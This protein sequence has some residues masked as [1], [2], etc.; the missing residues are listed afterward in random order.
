MVGFQFALINF[1]KFRISGKRNKFKEAEALCKR[2]LDIREKCLG[3]SHPDV[4]KQLN[5]LALLCQNQGKYD[6]VESYYRRAIEIYIKTLGI[7]DPNV[8]KTKNNLASA[9]LKQQKYKE[10][11]Q[12]YKDVLTRAQEKECLNKPPLISQQQQET[13]KCQQSKNGTTA[14]GNYDA[15]GGWYKTILTDQPTVTTTLKN[16]SLLY[17]R[18]GKYEAAETLENCAAKARKDPQAI[19]QALNFVKQTNLA[20]HQ[21]QPPAPSW[22]FFGFFSLYHSE[23]WN[24]SI[25]HSKFAFF[26]KNLVFIFNSLESL[27]LILISFFSA[28]LLISF[29]MYMFTVSKAISSPNKQ[30]THFSF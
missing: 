3:S 13:Q 10:A 21:Q 25:D 29:A 5:N 27:L 14:G 6:E 20:T 17:R 4:A 9:Y 11:E 15:Q 16:L 28:L 30:K 26:S 23:Q 18:Q 2:A 1:W 7:D 12:I 19:L 22:V 8:A 24:I